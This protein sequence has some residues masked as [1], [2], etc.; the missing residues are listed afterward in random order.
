MAPSAGKPSKPKK[1][2]TKKPAK[3]KAKQTN[4][5]QADDTENVE[6][7]INPGDFTPILRCEGVVGWRTE[8][9]ANKFDVVENTVLTP[10]DDQA[11]IKRN[12]KAWDKTGHVDGVHAMLKW[13]TEPT[14]V[15]PLTRYNGFNNER[16]FVNFVDTVVCDIV[17]SGLR[18]L[19]AK[20]RVEVA[21]SLLEEYSPDPTSVPQS[22]DATWVNARSRIIALGSESNPQVLI[23][24]SE[25]VKQYTTNKALRLVVDVA[26]TNLQKPMFLPVT[27]AVISRADNE[28][29]GIHVVATILIIAAQILLFSP[30]SWHKEIQYCRDE[31]A[32][33]HRYPTP[34]G[35]GGNCR[36]VADLFSLEDLHRAIVMVYLVIYL[37]KDG[38]ISL[39]AGRQPQPR[40]KWPG[41]FD[42]QRQIPDDTCGMEG[43]SQLSVKVLLGKIRALFDWDDPDEVFA[44]IKDH[45]TSFA[46]LIGEQHLVD[47]AEQGS[48]STVIQEYIALHPESE[49]VLNNALMRVY[50]MDTLFNGM[51]PDEHTDIQH[52]CTQYGI[53]PYPL[54]ELYPDEPTVQSL[55]P[56]QV[57]DIGI[58]SEKLDTLGHVLLSNEMGLG[59]T[60]VFIAIIECR[61]RELEAKLSSLGDD[62]NKDIFFPTL[63]VNPPATIY[64]TAEE[65]KENFPSLNVLMYYATP[66]QAGKLGRARVILKRHFIR[67]LKKLSNSDPQTARTVIMTTYNT[68]QTREQVKTEHRFIFVNRKQKG[69]AKKRAKTMASPPRDPLGDVDDEFQAGVMITE[70][71]DPE[72]SESESDSDDH[73]TPEQTRRK[74][75]RGKLK[76]YYKGSYELEGKRLYFLAKNDRRPADGNLIEY[77]LVTGTP[78]MGS[79]QDIISPLSLIW[80]QLD[81]K[82]T[83]GKYA[84]GYSLGLWDKDYDPNTGNTWPD[85]SKTKGIFSEQFMAEHPA[86]GWKQ[87]QD[88]YNRTGVKIWQICPSLV[89][90]C[91]SEA[92]WSSGFGQKVVSV[93][94]K[95]VSLHRTLRSRLALPDGQISYPGA[96]LL[97]MTI[98]T[99]ELSFDETLRAH[100][101]EHGRQMATNTFVPGPSTTLDNFTP[102]KSSRSQSSQKGS[103]NFSAY[104]EGILVTYDWRNSNILY[105]NVEQIFG[106]Q[107]PDA[108]GNALRMLREKD[109]LTTSQH[110][111]L[112][113][114]AAKNSMPTIGVEHI[115][116]LLQNEENEGM[117]YFFTRTC[118]DPAVLTLTDRST[119]I[120]W[121]CYNNPMLA[122]IL[123]LSHRYVLEEKRRLLIYVDT[124]WIQ[125]MMLG[126]LLMAGYKTVTVRSSDKPPAKLAAIQSFS[127]PKSDTQI[128]IANI[129]IMSTGVNLHHACSR[130]ILATFHF[131][132]KTLQQVHGRLNRLGQKEA[133][134]WHNIKVKDSFHDHQERMLLMKWVKQLSAEC[135]LP[136]WMTGALRELMLYE[137]VRSYFNQPFNRYGWVILAERDGKQMDY[138]SEEAIKLGY[139]CSL[140]AKL[141]LITD[142]QLY[143]TEH[144]DYLAV[145]ML[146]L[147]A[148]QPMSIFEEWLTFAEG[149]L[150]VVLEMRLT[151]FIEEAKKAKGEQAKFYRRRM[152]ERQKALAEE[153]EISDDYDSDGEVLED[154]DLDF[155]S[156]TEDAAVTPGDLDDTAAQEQLEVARDA[157]QEPAEAAAGG[158]VDP[159]DEEKT[160]SANGGEQDGGEE[161]GASGA[162]PSNQEA[163]K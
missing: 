115:Q 125:Q 88:F 29:D 27:R 122:R 54:L 75:A 161:G 136:E 108:I 141:I 83:E 145:A 89:E 32:Y 18:L 23:Q 121:L 62:D 65:I 112:Q 5:D 100:V 59:K 49:E 56:H 147:V 137:L 106:G 53:K 149:R 81:F 72:P 67:T 77:K 2:S 134:I 40:G 61:A 11:A 129:N 146:D 58:I 151:K 71:S 124:P 8:D 44:R 126:A 30:T 6:N 37:R 24:P 91:G 107:D 148:S 90:S 80:H 1:P 20:F 93:I 96:D 120:Y 143:Y 138:Y 36:T 160:A 48:A 42:N 73:H 66:S 28:G 102:S 31:S 153:I 52:I 17:P 113:R 117:T 99:E 68:L 38:I 85:G 132:A 156:D 103:M 16:S 19:Q 64:Q 39:K 55:K 82:S 84:I 60:K 110:Q 98:I 87:M 79:L 104:R 26:I 157:V 35:H 57:A 101:Q 133:V 142:K 14:N 47:F 114:T 118:T 43:A 123:E 4:G 163:I 158:E 13:N 45:T 34:P 86:E 74:E 46:S 21:K 63:I 95:I 25:V 109:N 105:A 140:V 111:R 155:A 22:L 33:Q 41:Y 154:E 76:K 152:E 78:L 131:N 119:W 12:K 3:A 130:G 127:D 159:T 116:K 162:P 50:S 51:P 7:A 128:F 94:L 92:K 10:D 97:P 9:I 139:A 150:R 135:S 144:D 70:D 69:P 15:T